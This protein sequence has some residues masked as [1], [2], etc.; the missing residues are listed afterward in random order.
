LDDLTENKCPEWSEGE[1]KN[2]IQTELKLSATMAAMFF[3]SGSS[4][5]GCQMMEIY[6]SDSD[7]RLLHIPA[8]FFGNKWNAKSSRRFPLIVAGM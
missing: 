1:V 4:C 2:V 5:R 3:I 6:S 7:G 8:I